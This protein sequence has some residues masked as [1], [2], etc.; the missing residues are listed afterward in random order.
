MQMTCIESARV[1][2]ALTWKPGCAIQSQGASSAII[3]GSNWGRFDSNALICS[4][5]RM[6]KFVRRTPVCMVCGCAALAFG[7][8]GAAAQTNNIVT[9]A[10]TGT[11]GYS[12][13][14]GP[15][16]SADLGTPVGVKSMPDGGYLIFNQGGSVV[17]RVF[18]D[19]IIRTV[20]GNGTNAFS[21][22]TGPAI[23]ASMNAP[24]GGDITADGGYLIADANNNRIRRVAPDGTIT[25]VV[26]DGSQAFGG[27]NGPANLAQVRF[28]YYLIADVDNQRIR[29]VAPDGTITTVAGGGVGGDGGPATSAQL[30][31]PEG[32]A[33]TADGGYLIADTFAHRVR[34]VDPTGTI[35]TVAGTG[36]AGLT[37]DGGPATLATLNTP[38][39]V[40]VE[41]NGG[42]VIADTVNHRL[43]R[44]APDGTITTVAG[45][46]SGFGGDGGQATAAQLNNPIGVAVTTGGDYLIAD[47]S[48]QRIRFVDAAS[49]T[50]AFTRSSPLSPANENAPRII[51]TS[52]AN[53]M[54]SLYTNPSCTGASVGNSPAPGFAAPGIAV[55]VA[56]NST[57]TFFA[58]ATDLA[59]F[60][61]PCSS[62]SLTY[63]ESTPP[64]PLPPPVRGVSVNAIPLAGTV[65]VRL[66]SSRKAHAAATGFV[67]L[68]SVGRQIPVGSTLDTSKGTVLLTSATTPTG[69]AQQGQFSSGLF[70]I[71]QGRKNALTTL[72]MTGGGLNS[73]SK[74]PRGG[75][76]KLAPAKL[77]RR[78]LFSNVK[79]RFRTR[80]RNSAATVRG[81]KW[82]MTDTCAG[83]LTR[84][85]TGSVNVRDFRLRKTIVVKAGRSY[86]ARASLRKNRHR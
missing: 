57:T 68:E 4:D 19:G 85:T 22:D 30:T 1:A 9:V 55:S 56:D 27:D 11:A 16:T 5:R 54:V 43:R 46:T 13:D 76:P 6:R 53:S 2:R 18:P 23:S 20:A 80:G 49:P 66:S 10:G 67:P 41:P 21:G 39:R 26:G 34:R 86:L 47:T 82:T 7:A 51:G 83:T 25:T 61:S 84:V 36:Q 81:T 45:T 28:P 65:L 63:V 38:A 78:T 24:S 74:L 70:S 50:P 33:L 75:S 60:A 44:V 3:A 48:N 79:G 64:P 71:S 69:G 8:I 72:S 77:M 58:T 62:S 52:F 40:A 73:C 37:G 31:K 59:G 29:R 12:G 15:A 35:T 32:V 14:G 17:R 42:F